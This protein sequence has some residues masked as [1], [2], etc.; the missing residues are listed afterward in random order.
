MFEGGVKVEGTPAFGACGYETP[1]LNPEGKAKAVQQSELSSEVKKRNLKIYEEGTYS[2]FSIICKTDGTRFPCHKAIIAASSAHFARQFESGTT[3]V[4]IEGYESEVVEAFIKFLYFP[5]VNKEIL[6]KDA[7]TF[8]KMADQYN[9]PKLKEAVLNLEPAFLASEGVKGGRGIGK[10]GAKR[11]R[12]I[13]RDNIQGSIKFAIRR[14]ARRGGVKRMSGLI[15]EEAK[16]VIKVFLENVI[17]DAVTNTDHN[18]RTTVTA[19]DVVYALKKQG[20]TMYG[21]GG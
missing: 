10:G 20:R 6:K 19:M 7:K 18:K 17:L 21:F 1:I 13:L 12:K 16:D 5:A 15:Y 8:L 4:E 9:V 3:E 2:D 11:H 14:L